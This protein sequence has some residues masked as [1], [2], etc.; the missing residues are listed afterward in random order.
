MVARLKLKEIDGRAPQGVKI[1]Y[2]CNSSA[3]KEAV[4]REAHLTH[5]GWVYT[6]K[7]E[8]SLFYRISVARP[9]STDW[10]RFRD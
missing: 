9:G 3:P 5:V 2:S 4:S 6:L 1:Y 8:E 7:H 10:G